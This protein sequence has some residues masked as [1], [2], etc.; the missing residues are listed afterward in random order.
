MATAQFFMIDSN[1]PLGPKSPQYEW[2]EKELA[3]SKATWKF[4]CHH[5]PCF[6]SEEND[7]GDHNKGAEGTKFGL[8]DR[9]ARQLVPLYEKYG[10]DIAFN[11]HI[12][13]YERTWPIFEMAINQQKGVR[14][15]TSGGGGGSLEQ[16]A[17]QRHLVQPALSEGVPLLLRRDQRPHDRLQG[18]RH[19]RPDVRHVRADEGGGSVGLA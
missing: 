10:V 11:G 9:N 17:P 8:G 4:T 14:Y 5:H 16:A 2:L 6:S 19:R 15:L 7:Y 18:L 3:A 12:H 1:K 13:L